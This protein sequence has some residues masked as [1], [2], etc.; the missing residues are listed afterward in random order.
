[1][2]ERKVRGGEKAET[3][4]RKG[5]GKSRGSI[6]W[7]GL[8]TFWSSLWRDSGHTGMMEVGDQQAAS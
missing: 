3:K 6:R 7:W 8:H 4:K 1:M 5:A 2:G